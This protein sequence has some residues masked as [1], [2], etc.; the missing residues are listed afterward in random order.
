MS[1]K[2]D[3]NG[4]PVTQREFERHLRSVEAGLAEI[5]SAVRDIDRKVEKINSEKIP[6][7]Q[8]RDAELSTKAKII[9]G[10][11]SS[12]AGFVASILGMVI[13]FFLGG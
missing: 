13:K 7:L 8:V 9:V 3:N 6:S 2:S 4:S 12:G 1:D 11:I 10:A 5:K